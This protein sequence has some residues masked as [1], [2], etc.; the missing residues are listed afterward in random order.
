LAERFPEFRYE[1]D[2]VEVRE[3]IKPLHHGGIEDRFTIDEA[4]APVFFVGDPKTGGQMTS[5]TGAFHDGVLELTPQQARNFTITFTEAGSREPIGYWS[6]D[7][8]FPEI[9]P[10]PVAGVRNRALVFDGKKTQLTTTLNTSALRNGATFSLWVKAD[11]PT[12]KDQVALGARSASEEFAL[13]WNLGGRSGFGY[14]A[15]GAGEPNGSGLCA[16][17]VDKGWHQL[18]ATFSEGKLALFCDGQRTGGISASL[19]ANAPIVIGSAG[20]TKFAAAT[21]DEVRIYDR[22][23]SD[24]EIRALYDA[25]RQPQFTPPAL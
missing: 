4:T 25:D 24:D 19:P 9:K 12:A 14:I 13:G 17:V 6:M 3:L 22:A 23:L 20:G 15:K 7:D 8:S 5:N 21:L 10:L 16:S 18:A 1:I 2:G 11:N